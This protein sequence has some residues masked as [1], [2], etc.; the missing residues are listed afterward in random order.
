MSFSPSLKTLLRAVSGKTDC[1]TFR[2]LSKEN[3]F[4][5][6]EYCA[7]L[8]RFTTNHHGPVRDKKINP[9]LRRD[10][11]AEFKQFLPN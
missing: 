9:W 10:A 8:L 4:F 1:D 3:Y 6:I 7:R 2:S 5:A 11:V